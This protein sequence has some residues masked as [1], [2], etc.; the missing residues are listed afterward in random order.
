MA[1]LA[2]IEWNSIDKSRS[3]NAYLKE[4]EDNELNFA[5]VASEKLKASAFVL[6]PSSRHVVVG[7]EVSFLP[8]NN[9]KQTFKHIALRYL[10]SFAMT[11]TNAMKLISAFQL[12]MRNMISLATVE[13]RF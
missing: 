1:C 5:P 13:F 11:R 4:N 6:A 3:A 9:C 12:E 10:N 2:T 8:N 7:F